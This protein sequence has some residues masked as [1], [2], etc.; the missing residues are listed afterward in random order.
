MRHRKEMWLITTGAKNIMNFYNSGISA[1]GE[2]FYGNLLKYYDRDFP[3]PNYHQ[4]SIDL[5]RTFPEEEAF[6]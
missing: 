2:T 6:S 3:N 4:I 1:K 5:P